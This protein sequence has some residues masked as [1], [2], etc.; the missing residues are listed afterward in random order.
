[1][2]F[3]TDLPY[4]EI[5]LMR[6]PT[7]IA[8]E[9]GFTL[10][11]LL[12]VIAIIGLLVALLLPAVQSA[13]EAARR[14][15]CANHLKQIGLA[16][17]SYSQSRGALPPARVSGGGHATWAV[18]IL[19]YMEQSAIAQHWDFEKS[20]YLQS[21][22]ARQAQIAIYLCPSRRGVPQLSI[23]GD[24]PAD[25]PAPTGNF[26][27]H[28]PGSLG[29]YACTVHHN[30]ITGF[31]KSP[32]SMNYVYSSGAM[33]RSEPYSDPWDWNDLVQDSRWKHP[34]GWADILDRTSNTL[35]VGEKHVRPDNFGKRTAGPGAGG[36]TEFSGEDGDNAIFNGDHY[37]TFARAAGPANTLAR[38]PTEPYNTNFGS[39][40]PGVCQFVLCDGSVRAIN[41]TIDGVN[42]G[43]LVQRKDGEAVTAR[44]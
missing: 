44:Y 27:V 16:V 31:Q 26:L 6:R 33:I 13:R 35:L 23:S 30:A 24:V 15:Q 19:P 40:H 38:Y 34:F 18:R 42:L 7:A 32:P 11:E 41:V 3:L 8:T 2:P 10:V 43:R 28:K 25:D 9:R 4:E 17:Q 22:T 21:D 1:M 5:H 37:D 20:Y 14:S 12:V 36:S 29:D 39:Y